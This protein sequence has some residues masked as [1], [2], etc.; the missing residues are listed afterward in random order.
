MEHF[1]NSNI[2]EGSSVTSVNLYE[3]LDSIY[4]Q[5]H[6]TV[7]ANHADE[8]ELW[9]RNRILQVRLLKGENDKGP[10]ITSFTD[11]DKKTVARE[12]FF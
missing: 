2:P 12:V 9:N 5:V 10:S 11:L 6:F 1:I 8:H 3:Y 7:S 4:V